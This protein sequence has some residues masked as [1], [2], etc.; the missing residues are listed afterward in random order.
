MAIN[1]A[2]FVRDVLFYIKN[3][4]LANITDPIAAKRDDQSKF[5]MTSYPSRKTQYPL[6]TIKLINKTAAR[7]GMQTTAMDVI[8]TL[9]IRIWGRNQKEKEELYTDVYNRL[10][11]I[12]FTDSTGSVAV[13]LNDFTERSAVELDEE[14]DNMPKSRIMQVEYK[15]FNVS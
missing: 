6:L 8:I 1:V 14:G 12:Q 13:G 10:K 5:I 7:A 2:T 9:E 3:D 11:D 15:F 4:L